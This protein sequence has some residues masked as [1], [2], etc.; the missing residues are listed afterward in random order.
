MPK[1]KTVAKA[2]HAFAYFGETDTKDCGICSYCI[3]KKKSPPKPNR[4]QKIDRAA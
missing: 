4:F 3:S 1:I 2:G